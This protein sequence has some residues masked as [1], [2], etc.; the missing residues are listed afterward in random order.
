M[1]Q[2][3]NADGSGDGAGPAMAVRREDYAAP[4]YWIDSV[5]LTFDQIGRAHV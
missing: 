3:H 5:D 1:L 4:A 2:L